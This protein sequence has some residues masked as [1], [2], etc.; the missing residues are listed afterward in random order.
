[1]TFLFTF[2]HCIINHLNFSSFRLFFENA[3]TISG[4]GEISCRCTKHSQEKIHQPLGKIR[5]TEGK[6]IKNRPA[7]GSFM[8]RGKKKQTEMFAYYIKHV[9]G[10]RFSTTNFEAYKAHLN[11]CIK[12]VT[13]TV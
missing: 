10:L 7:N 1:M 4:N 3:F 8:E 13:S 5:I 2:G 11:H 6:Q 12:W 9:D